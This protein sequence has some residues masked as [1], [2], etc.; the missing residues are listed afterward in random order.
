MK[1]IKPC[2]ISDCKRFLFAD[3]E[4]KGFNLRI[5]VDDDIKNGGIF[6]YLD[7]K[8]AEKILKDKD[9]LTFKSNLGYLSTRLL[10]KNTAFCEYY[11]LDKEKAKNIL[12][13]KYGGYEVWRDDW[14]WLGGKE[15]TKKI[16]ERKAKAWIRVYEV[17]AKALIEDL[18]KKLLKK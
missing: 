8:Q 11:K 2:K 14:E 16:S 17:E 3:Y 15:R 12:F 9:S 18:A 7:D 1:R 13:F 4:H 6:F 5:A 10:I